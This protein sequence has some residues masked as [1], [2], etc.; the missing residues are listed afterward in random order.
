[1]HEGEM[2]KI[3]WVVEIKDG[4]GWRPFVF[5]ETRAEGRDAAK[6]FNGFSHST[7][8]ATKRVKKYVR[9]EE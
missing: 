7:K 4:V 3:L 8:H 2:K 1:M 6:Y 9:V 5:T